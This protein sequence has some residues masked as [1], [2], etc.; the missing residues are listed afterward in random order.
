[1]SMKQNPSEGLPRSDALVL[2]GVG[3]QWEL[4]EAMARRWL[5]AR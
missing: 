4:P 3:M 5:N 2:F 1:M